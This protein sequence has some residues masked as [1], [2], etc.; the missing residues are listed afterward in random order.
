MYR[1]G[2]FE[3]LATNFENEIIRIK[4]KFSDVGYPLRYIESVIRDF[5]KTP[6]ADDEGSIIPE[7]LFDD[8]KEFYVRIPFCPKNEEI[9]RTF[10]QKLNEYT[11]NKYNFKIIWNTRNIR[12]L[13]PLKDRVKH[14]S[15][16]I[17]EGK[18]SCGEEYIGETV[19][20]T[21]IRWNEHIPLPNRTLTDPGK[22]IE[23]NS[24]HEFKW[25][26]ITR[27][28]RNKLKRLI[29]EAYFIAKKRPKINVQINPKLLLLYRNGIT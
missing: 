26:V 9:S 22:H 7:W 2:T 10:L 4:K 13:F 23:E 1:L 17:Y 27:A 15:C 14:Q 12:S 6:D 20:M 18:C 24:T 11:N 29:L 3:K 8:R 21:D 16:V 25:K 19:R 5:Q 28:P